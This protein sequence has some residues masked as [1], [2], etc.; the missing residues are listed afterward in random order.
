VRLA[1][2]LGALAIA[3]GC[4]TAPALNS[5]EEDAPAEVENIVSTSVRIKRGKKGPASAE[6]EAASELGEVVRVVELLA[7]S[8]AK[9]VGLRTGGGDPVEVVTEAP[10]PKELLL[11]V[12]LGAEGAHAVYVTTAA[13]L[14]RGGHPSKPVPGGKPDWDALIASAKTV[15]AVTSQPLGI[16]VGAAK[17]SRAER[18]VE[19]LKRVSSALPGPRPRRLFAW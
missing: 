1:A 19:V 6:I 7:R 10:K 5:E 16:S 3:G 9:K 18:A 2:L 8:G 4:V 13:E 14:S 15:A 12:E 17:D 11:V